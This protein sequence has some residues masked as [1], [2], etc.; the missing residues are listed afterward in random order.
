[1]TAVDDNRTFNFNSPEQSRYTDIPCSS[2]GKPV[3]VHLS[4]DGLYIGCA[5]C[6][7]CIGGF[8]IGTEQFSEGREF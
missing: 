4:S 7:D 8:N 6:E 2:C 1:M 3:R 5:W